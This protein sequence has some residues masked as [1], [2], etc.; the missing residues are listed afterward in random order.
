MYDILRTAPDTPVLLLRLDGL[1]KFQRAQYD[2][3]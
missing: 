3:F 1:G 2:G